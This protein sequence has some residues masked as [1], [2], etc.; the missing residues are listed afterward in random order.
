L[1]ASGWHTAAIAMAGRTRRK[2]LSLIAAAVNAGIS[3]F[4]RRTGA[5]ARKSAIVHQR[6][7]NVERQ[8]RPS[9]RARHPGSGCHII[10]VIGHRDRGA[11]ALDFAAP[12]K[13]PQE[14]MDNWED[15]DL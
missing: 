13:A 1:I 15:D 2:S 9:P 12:K 7:Q 8:L 6:A 4:G 14:A 11:Q 10:V 5:V 3:C